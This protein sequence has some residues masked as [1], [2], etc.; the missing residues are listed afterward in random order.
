MLERSKD[1]PLGLH[2]DLVTRKRWVDVDLACRVLINDSLA[3]WLAH[4]KKKSCDVC[5]HS[6]AFTKGRPQRVISRLGA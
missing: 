1:A 2:V 5:K 4:S 3:T 6:Y